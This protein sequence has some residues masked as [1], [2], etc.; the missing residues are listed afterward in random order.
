[1]NFTS[2]IDLFREWA[3]V[4]CWGAFEADVPRKY[5]VAAIFKRAIGQGRIQRIE[6]LDQLRREHGRWIC[7][8]NFV[9]VGAP[10]RDWK[11]SLIGDG[12]I[13]VRH[14]DWASAWRLMERCVGDLR[15]IAG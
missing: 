3:R 14:P 2:D 11:S 15:L 5:N 9:P 8:E 10:R 12:F 1:M 7:W 6:G 13:V 4:V